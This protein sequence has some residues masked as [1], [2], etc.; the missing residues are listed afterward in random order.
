MAEKI[1]LCEIYDKSENEQR[2]AA[3]MLR[4]D[5]PGKIPILVRSD[6]KAALPLQ[7]KVYLCDPSQTIRGLMI[8]VRKMA[9]I[10]SD[11]GLFYYIG[12]RILM[13]NHT[14]GSLDADKE[15]FLRIMVGKESVFGILDSIK[16]Q[17]S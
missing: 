5:H 7:T 9:K 3:M 8:T 11:E 17:S 12:N 4:R 14:V 16:A 15:D 1:K 10:S 2:R 13:A 6:P